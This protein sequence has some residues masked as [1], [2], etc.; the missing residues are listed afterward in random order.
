M[1][2][3]IKHGSSSAERSAVQDFR[4]WTVKVDGEEISVQ[5]AIPT[6]IE[7]EQAC[8]IVQDFARG[9]FS[10]V[11]VKQR[12]TKW[13]ERDNDML[14]THYALWPGRPAPE[15]KTFGTAGEA[16]TLWAPTS[17]FVS[18]VLAMF[19]NTKRTVAMRFMPFQ[20]LR[21]MVEDA[22]KE[23]LELKVWHASVDGQ[24]CEHTFHTGPRGHMISWGDLWDTDFWDQ[25]LRLQWAADVNDESKP[26]VS[27]PGT[28]ALN[29][30]VEVFWGVLR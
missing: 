16:E 28:W 30:L 29:M 18:G 14:N 3:K 5:V 13:R 20:I 8:W 25:K 19:R 2:P 1:P 10:S 21:G 24:V 6:A 12:T 9:V 27:T 15:Y 17:L 11:Q 26:W 7:S 4:I 23:D 22:C